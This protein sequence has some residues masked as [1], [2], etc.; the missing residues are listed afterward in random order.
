MALLLPVGNCK[1]LQLHTLHHVGVNGVGK[2]CGQD[3]VGVNDVWYGVGWGDA[4]VG[5]V[6]WIDSGVDGVGG[7]HACAACSNMSLSQVSVHD[8]A[9]V[10]AFINDTY[11]ADV[12][13]L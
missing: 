9:H 2:L 7:Q 12:A 5:S 3:G 1:A 10:L 11:K 13:Q 4:G 6:A 8:P